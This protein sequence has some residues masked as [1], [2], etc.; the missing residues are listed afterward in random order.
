MG[1]CQDEANFT[2]ICPLYSNIRQ[3]LLNLILIDNPNFSSLSNLDQ[4]IYLMQFWQHAN[5]VSME[6]KIF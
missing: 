6:D 4:I 5:I 3:R 2:L 1:L